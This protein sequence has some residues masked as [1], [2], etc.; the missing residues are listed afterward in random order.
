MIDQ[1]EGRVSRITIHWT[2]R[3]AV[4]RARSIE[5]RT[6]YTRGIAYQSRITNE[7][8]EDGGDQHRRPEPGVEQPVEVE[9]EG[10][11]PR[12]QAGGHAHR[13]GSG[14]EPP[15]AAFSSRRNIW[16]PVSSKSMRTERASSPSASERKVSSVR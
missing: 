13:Q 2:S 16:H 7:R 1:G 11:A 14:V 12:A 8:D 5:S 15:H 3:S 4:A 9:A 6:K 10:L